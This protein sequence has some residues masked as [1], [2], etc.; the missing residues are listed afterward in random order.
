MMTGALQLVEK[1]VRTKA[2]PKCATRRCGG[3]RLPQGYCADCLHGLVLRFIGDFMTVENAKQMS[4]FWLKHQLGDRIDLV[5]AQ[6]MKDLVVLE[7]Q[8]KDHFRDELSRSNLHVVVGN[9][10]WRVNAGS[11]KKMTLWQRLCGF[12]LVL[13]YA[14]CLID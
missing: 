12:R 4:L 8:L 3:E 11:T 10:P 1:R 7:L 13:L 14:L 2:V 5:E 9:L 6:A